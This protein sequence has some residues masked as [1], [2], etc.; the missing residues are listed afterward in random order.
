MSFV[1]ETNVTPNELLAPGEEGWMITGLGAVTNDRV[2]LAGGRFGG[3]RTTQLLRMI[4]VIPEDITGDG[5]VGADDLALLLAA[6]GTGSLG[7]F[8]SDSAVGA[9][10][11]GLLLA[12]WSA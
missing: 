6:W 9:A 8:D 11:L 12:A 10:D 3:S 7:D 5:T 4:P 2:I 1:G